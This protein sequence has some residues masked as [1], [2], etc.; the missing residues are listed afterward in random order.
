MQSGELD[1]LFDVLQ[2]TVTKN[3]VGQIKQEWIV[4][5]QFWGGIEPVST[6]AFVN[7][8]AQGSQIICRV[9]MRPSDFNIQPDYLLRVADTDE[10]YAIQ[11]KLPVDQ[12]KQA[13]LCSIGKRSA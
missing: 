9:V 1:H 6:N 12:S 4:I 13:L 8:G 7:S 11:G 5:G 3:P 2:R 10:I